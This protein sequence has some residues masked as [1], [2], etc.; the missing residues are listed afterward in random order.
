M[1]AMAATTATKRPATIQYDFVTERL[2]PIRH[3]TNARRK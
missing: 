1:A 3:L 2:Y